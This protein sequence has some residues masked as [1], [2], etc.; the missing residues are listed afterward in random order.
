WVYGTLPLFLTKATAHY[1]ESDT[2]LSNAVIDTASKFGIGLK[3]KTITGSGQVLNSKT[4]DSGYKANLIGRLLSAIVDTGTT[5]LVYLL[6]RELFNRKVGFLSAV[7]HVFTVLHI[8]YS[9]FYGAESWVAFFATL[10]MLL[11]VKLFKTI[12]LSGQ[13][14]KLANR[15]TLWLLLSVGF[16][17]GLTVASKLSGLTVG[18]V[19]IISIILCLASRLKSKELAASAKELAKFFGLGTF[20]LSVAFLAFRLFQPY[21]FSG[22]FSFDD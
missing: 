5:F 13:S 6:G 20:M 7:L 2:F 22:I 9:H 11:S 3:E 18:I 12:R 17:F 19:P 16:A 4:F 1:L 8:Q 14:G 21:A 10:T 15:R